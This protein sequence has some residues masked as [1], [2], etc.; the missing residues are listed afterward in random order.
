MHAIQL[1]H[2]VPC[3]Y[4]VTAKIQGVAFI[5]VWHFI[6][7]FAV[8]PEGSYLFIQGWLL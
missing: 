3:S 7:V 5:R 4:L 2:R 8:H 1:F 6:T